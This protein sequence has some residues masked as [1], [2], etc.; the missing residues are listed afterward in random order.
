MS[1]TYKEIQIAL[2]EYLKAWAK[3]KDLGVVGNKKDFTSQLSEFI[4]ATIY[5]G[6][7]ATNCNQQHWDIKLSDGR[8]VQVKAHAKSATNNNSWTPVP[9]SQDVEID[10]FIIVVFTENYKLK[11]FFEITWAELWGFSS[12]EKK[13]RT[14]RWNQIEKFDRI[15]EKKFRGNKLVQLFIN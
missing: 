3:L 1:T 11:H 4:V 5:R 9:Y 13:Y 6:K 8:K 10:L 7:P 12:G 14:I 15:N 2:S